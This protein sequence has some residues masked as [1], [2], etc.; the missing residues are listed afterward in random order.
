MNAIV[1][2]DI[3]KEL[4]VIKRDHILIKNVH[5]EKHLPVIKRDHILIKN[6]HQEKHHHVIKRED[7]IE[8]YQVIT[9]EQQKEKPIKKEDQIEFQKELELQRGFHI[10]NC[11]VVQ[12][13]EDIM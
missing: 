11:I 1:H 10:K 2:E 8:I 5:Q 4:R 6:V 3:K 13:E 12:V 7:L 9:K